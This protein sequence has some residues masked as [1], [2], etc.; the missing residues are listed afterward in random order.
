MCCYEYENTPIPYLVL[1]HVYCIQTDVFSL[2]R[3]VKVLNI[4][5]RHGDHVKV[6]SKSLLLSCMSQKEF[7][8]G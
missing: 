7:T 6:V 2:S 4:D 8:L 1:Y 5:T 3:N